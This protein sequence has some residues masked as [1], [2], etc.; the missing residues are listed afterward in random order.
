M[1]IAIAG[2]GGVGKTTLA[3][4][5]A[6][7]LADDGHRVL[8][9]DADPDANLA[10]MLPLDAPSAPRPLAAR[11]DIIDALTGRAWFRRE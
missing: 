5:L 7:H 3:G 9:I 11:R 10:S 1:K 6:R 8:A 4:F 2:K